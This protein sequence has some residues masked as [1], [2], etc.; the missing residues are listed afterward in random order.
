[1]LHSK[2]LL[3]ITGSIAAYKTGTLISKLIQEG[4]EVQ[5][6]ATKSALEFIGPGTLEGLTGN[7]VLSD[8][9][10]TGRM[11]DHIRLTK[12]ADITVLAPAS[13]NTLNRMAAGIGDSSVTALFLAHDWAKPYVIAPAMN[14]KMLN[15]PATKRSLKTLQSWG[16]HILPTASGYLACGAW[17][18]KRPR[19]LLDQHSEGAQEEDSQCCF[20]HKSAMTAH[21]APVISRSCYPQG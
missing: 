13:A 10:E 4:C 8:V 18:E 17:T 21:I 6:V 14:T 3:K 7:P 20:W 19:S 15:H 5:T 12:W 1:M 9:F 11:M 16:A 2:I